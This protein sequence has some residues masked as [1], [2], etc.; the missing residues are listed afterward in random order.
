MKIK[1]SV[2]PVTRN[3]LEFMIAY[4]CSN[5]CTPTLRE[6]G[7]ELHMAHTS[8]LRH[9]DRLEAYGYIERID[10]EGRRKRP[11]RIPKDLQRG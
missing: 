9:L 1:R 4:K 2:N 6:I 11:Y 10:P 5:D 7:L 8:V 3:I